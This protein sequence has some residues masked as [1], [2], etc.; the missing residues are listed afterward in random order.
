V[1]VSNEKKSH[2]IVRH[3]A[4]YVLIWTT[5]WAGMYGDD[6]AK[7][8][9]MARIAGSVY[10]DI[11]V[12]NFYMDK[13]NKPSDM[14]RESL[15][16]RL[17]SWKLSPD[18]EEL[19]LFK[20]AYTTKNKMVRIYKVLKV[21]KESKEFVELCQDMPEEDI[22]KESKGYPPALEQILSKKR[23]FKQLEDFNK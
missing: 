23:D 3:L 10:K 18:V 4:D 16:Y 11:D 1:L 20:E 12:A 17:H 9:H 14:M 5:R 22:C 8:P 21:D 2:Q 6:L 13:D 19:E 15:L 7:S